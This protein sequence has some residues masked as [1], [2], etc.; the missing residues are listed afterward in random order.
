MATTFQQKPQLI[1][2]SGNDIMF[3]FKSDD[4]NILFFNVEVMDHSAN[5]VIK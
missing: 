3:Q 2:P 5:L 4:P 1:S